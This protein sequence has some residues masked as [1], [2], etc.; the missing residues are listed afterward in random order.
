MCAGLLSCGRIVSHK[1]D[2]YGTVLYHYEQK[3]NGDTTWH[4]KSE[5]E[6]A[7][8]VEDYDLLQ[9][10]KQKFKEDYEMFKQL[11]DK[12]VTLE[13]SFEKLLPVLVLERE[14]ER[15]EEQQGGEQEHRGEK[16][17]KGGEQ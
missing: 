17:E 8:V 16:L 6:N 14:E 3:Q 7:L 10:L 2:N 12:V 5:F 11:K 9:L 15:E 13:S 4:K 1:L